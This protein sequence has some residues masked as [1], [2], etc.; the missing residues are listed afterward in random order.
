MHSKY[1]I[2]EKQ[3]RDLKQ[4]IYLLP[5]VGIIPAIW[6]LTNSQSPRKQK[7]ASRLSIGLFIT[8]LSLYILLFLG[9]D[10]SPNILAF[11]LL[12]ANALMTTGY[13]VSCLILMMV[14]N[15]QNSIYYGQIKKMIAYKFSKKRY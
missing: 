12:S 14:L 13:F 8:W 4:W 2:E 10:A 6:T 11:R 15:P 9:A 3:N 5:I 1:S 7:Q